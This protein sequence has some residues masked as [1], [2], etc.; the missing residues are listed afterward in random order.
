[1]N[2]QLLVATTRSLLLID[3]QKER[4]FIIDDQNGVYHGIARSE[5]HFYVSARRSHYGGTREERHA[6]HGVILKYDNNLNMVGIIES[7]FPLRDLHGSGWYDGKLWVCA[8]HDNMIAIFDEEGWEQWY[9]FGQSRN[10][11]DRDRNH[12]NSIYFDQEEIILLGNKN[13]TGTLW[14]FDRT[15][16]FP[17][18]N[19]ELGQGSHNIWKDKGY[20]FILSSATGNILLDKGASIPVGGYCRGISFGKDNIYIGVSETAHRQ[21]RSTSNAKIQIQDKDY[22]QLGHIDIFGHGMV[23]EIAIVP[24]CTKH[25]WHSTQTN[26]VFDAVR[27]QPDEYRNNLPTLLPRIKSKLMNRIRHFKTQRAHTIQEKELLEDGRLSYLVS[28]QRSGRTWLSFLV[29][30]Y[31]NIR[32]RLNLE[33]DYAT[34]NLL[35]PTNNSSEFGY[36]NLPFMPA[37]IKDHRVPSQRSFLQGANLI[38][39]HRNV[40]DVLYSKY[41]KNSRLRLGRQTPTFSGSFRQYLI[42]DKFGVNRIANYYNKWAEKAERI[43]H[44]V[45]YEELHADT[46]HCVEKVL[47]SMGLEPDKE[48]I[49]QS[50]ALSSVEHMQW[51]EANRTSGFLVYDYSNIDNFRARVG[52]PNAYLEQMSRQDIDLIK[53]L[54]LKNLDTDGLKFVEALGV[55]PD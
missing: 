25:H 31:L 23:H 41:K 50:I 4:I 35:V 11:V 3:I 17:L 5:N 45:S 55:L 30:N 44:F 28:Y 27:S 24:D 7:S 38:F 42:N 14:A 20:L 46:F 29:A 54:M 48:I 9:P 51:L 39:V 34:S 1:M 47:V 8:T 18:W 36:K 37:L 40:Y 21:A 53:Q 16:R 49:N 33:I 13:N 12:I 19:L 10:P 6:Q 22:R 32:Y 2:E 26:I 15:S 43:S 52:K